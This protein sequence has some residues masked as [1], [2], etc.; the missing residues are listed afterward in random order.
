MSPLG[1]MPPPDTAARA[2]RAQQLVE[3]LYA[4]ATDQHGLPAVGHMRQVAAA[5]EGELEI[6]GWLHDVVEDGRADPQ[7]LRRELSLSE[8]EIE[9]LG[10]L[11]RPSSLSYDDYI[12]RLA[13]AEGEAGE[14]A[15]KVKLADLRVNLA[16]P[17]HPTRPDLRERYL[18]AVAR[19][20]G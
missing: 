16:R 12:E 1:Q 3:S 20:G 18:R 8:L 13:T 10:L 7:L 17:P 2:A 4:D 6:L 19:L 9:A 5:C 15:R 11:T 14:I